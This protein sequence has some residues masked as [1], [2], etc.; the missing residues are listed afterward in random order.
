MGFRRSEV[1]ILS[2]RLRKAYREALSDKLFIS[3]GDRLSKVLSKCPQAS[4]P[5]GAS[6]LDPVVV[7]ADRCDTTWQT[8]SLDSDSADISVG[9]FPDGDVDTAGPLTPTPGDSNTQ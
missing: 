5:G 3:K 8:L 4:V 2:P 9:L 1:R 6:P 7:L